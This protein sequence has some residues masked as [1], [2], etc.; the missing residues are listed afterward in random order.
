MLGKRSREK[1]RSGRLIT[2]FHRPRVVP[3]F[4]L[5][6]GTELPERKEKERSVKPIIKKFPLTSNP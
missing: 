6:D 4:N 2:F 5:I 3:E 1:S